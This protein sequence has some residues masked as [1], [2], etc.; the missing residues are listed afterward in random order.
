MVVNEIS[1]H[2]F[3]GAQGRTPP[4]CVIHSRRGFCYNFS[5]NDVLLNVVGKG[6]IGM[7]VQYLALFVVGKVKDDPEKPTKIKIVKI[8]CSS[9][10][11]LLMV[12]IY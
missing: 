3:E 4:K 5:M 11:T 6:K 12:W 2:F 7:I 9:S 1:L 10:R 8:L